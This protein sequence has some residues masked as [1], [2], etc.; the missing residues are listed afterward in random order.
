MDGWVWVPRV[1]GPLAPYAKG[2]ESWL[3]A[4]GFERSTVGKRSWQ[5]ARLSGWM[6][7]EG[8][9]TDELTLER[10]E[11]FLEAHRAAGHITFSSPR[12]M[13]LPLEYLREIGAVLA[14][15][16]LVTE[17]ALE[18]L[19]RDYRGYLTRER[20][21]VEHTIRGH[22]RVARLFVG[23]LQAPDKRL[24]L[25]R[26]TAADVSA[27]LARECPKRS[28]SGAMDL[29]FSL[30][31]LLRYLHVTGVI[32]APLV[33]A[34][35]GVADVRDRSL[36][37]GLEPAVVG[38]M[39][40]SCDRRTLLGQRDHAILVLLARLGL[41]AGEVAALTL[42]DIDWRRGELL[43]HGKG[44][45]HDVLPVPIDV[46][47]T[48]ASYLRRRGRFEGSRA[49]F[50][51]EHAPAGALS[52]GG[53]MGVV[54]RACVRAGVPRVGAHRLRHTAATEMLRAGASLEEI[55]QVLRH[56]RVE[57]TALYAKVDRGRLRELA[58]PWPEGGVA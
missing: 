51:R 2:F 55:G 1:P 49:V 33:W 57:T 52:A 15:P 42:D 20:G 41:R 58:R 9:D 13:R 7:C 21:L 22:E 34:V 12:S 44:G 18:N 28:V 24:V 10:M 17:G 30:R 39:L 16:P 40:T 37:R 38:R 26:L 3:L 53:V 29:V 48:I 50:L 47:E 46:G 25:E 19:L 11:Q 23:E 56:H 36:P 4:R 35:P 6:E 27:F 14:L 5:L 45:R 31:V 43:I 32:G 54:T 8:L